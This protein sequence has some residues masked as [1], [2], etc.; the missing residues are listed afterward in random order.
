MG[1]SNARITASQRVQND[2]SVRTF[3]PE[4]GMI[5]ANDGR[6]QSAADE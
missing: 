5:S 4:T 2:G 3:I 6:D 1:G